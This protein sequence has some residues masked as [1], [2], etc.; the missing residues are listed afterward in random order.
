[1]SNQK[2]K[3]SLLQN[4]EIS[5]PVKAELEHLIELFNSK[6]PSIP[7]D[8]LSERLKELKIIGGS[9]YLYDE[10]IKYSPQENTIFINKELLQ[11]EELDSEYSMM[12]ALISVMTA[13]DNYYGFG[14]NE[15]LNALNVGFN[16]ILANNVIGNDGLSAF[17]DEQ[18][19]V[20]IIGS[21]VGA[22][23]FFDAF[24]TNNPDLL[25]KQLLL[26]SGDF[27]KIDSVLNQINHNMY[28]RR[29]IKVSKLYH[30]EKELTSL[31]VSGYDILMDKELMGNIEYPGFQEMQAL[32][33]KKANKAV[34]KVM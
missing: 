21:S 26:R 11:K 9:K 27:K 3:E 7:L 17:Y 13:K 25:M 31:F 16:E 14:G 18:I 32:L 4:K 6:F 8:N 10:A 12:K 28:T 15:K 24:F 1:M 22:D 19:L 23:T 20:N 5:E 2:V 33:N 30:I 29:Q 34:E